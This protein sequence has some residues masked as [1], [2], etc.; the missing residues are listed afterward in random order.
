MSPVFEKG[1]S[2]AFS[3]QGLQVIGP[4]TT[5]KDRTARHTREYFEEIGY[6]LDIR[7]AHEK[8]SG[9]NKK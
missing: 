7:F 9:N 4:E 5:K 8:W 1:S 3:H 6:V 2:G